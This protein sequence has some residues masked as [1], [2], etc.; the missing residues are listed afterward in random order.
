MSDVEQKRLHL[1]V[2]EAIGKVTRT[3]VQQKL[4]TDFLASQKGSLLHVNIFCIPGPYSTVRRPAQILK[5]SDVFLLKM[6][7]TINH[8]KSR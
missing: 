5:I 8:V 2:V 6:K 1:R 4:K 7:I 3:D